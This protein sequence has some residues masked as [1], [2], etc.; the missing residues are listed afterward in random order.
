MAYCVEI[1]EK[2]SIEEQGLNRHEELNYILRKSNI[3]QY[4]LIEKWLQA[5]DILMLVCFT[6]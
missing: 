4:E 3:K 5:K 6:F 2:I 1:I